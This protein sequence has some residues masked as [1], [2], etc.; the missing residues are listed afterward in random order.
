MFLYIIAYPIR[1]IKYSAIK[2][3]TILVSCTGLPLPAYDDT[4]RG[5]LNMRNVH[6]VSPRRR[7]ARTFLQSLC[8]M[9]IVLLLFALTGGLPQLP[10]WKIALLILGAAGLSGG[11]ARIMN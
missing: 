8:G 3:V 11:I 1:K 2:S 9:L 4:E 6:P 10:N 5:A 7:A